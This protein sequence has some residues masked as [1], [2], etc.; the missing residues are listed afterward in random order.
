MAGTSIITDADVFA[1]DSS[2]DSE[3]GSGRPAKFLALPPRS[4]FTTPRPPQLLPANRGAE[5]H[6][7]CGEQLGLASTA[8]AGLPGQGQT[9]SEEPRGNYLS[10]FAG[11]GQD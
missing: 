4:P 7:V 8:A 10:E 11:F 9:V 5:S 1:V 3:I 6:Q 2:S